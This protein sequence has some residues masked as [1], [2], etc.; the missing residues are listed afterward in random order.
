[1]VYV[2]QITSVR[3]PLFKKTYFSILGNLS[4]GNREVVFIGHRRGLTET[5]GH[6]G[7]VL[8]LAISTD[9]KYLVY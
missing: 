4:S 7:H 5:V 9:D 8:A 2:Y 6:T 3:Y 1:M